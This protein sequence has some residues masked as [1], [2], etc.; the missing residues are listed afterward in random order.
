MTEM[1]WKRLRWCFKWCLDYARVLEPVGEAHEDVVVVSSNPWSSPLSNEWQA[2]YW[3]AQGYDV[4]YI[5]TEEVA[6][7]DRVNLCAK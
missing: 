7:E 5:G 6:K 4:H 2:R 1:H 3:L